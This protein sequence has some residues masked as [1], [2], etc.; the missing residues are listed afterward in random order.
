[1]SDAAANPGRSLTATTPARWRLPALLLLVL[2]YVLS[3]RLGLML[4]IPPGYASAIFPPAGIALAA[5][6]CGGSVTLPW[7]FAG[8]LLLNLWVSFGAAGQL[9]GRGVAAGLA[10]ALA[11]S[12]QA[13]VG[14]A[15]LRRALG[16]PTPM[17]NERSLLRFILVSPLICAVSASV[18]VPSLLWLGFIPSDNLA[19]SWFTWWIG[20]TLG[21]LVMMPLTMVLVGQPRALWRSRAA[22]LYAPILIGFCLFVVIFARLSQW[23][24]DQSLVEFKLLSRQVSER[25]QT[26]LEAQEALLEQTERLFASSDYVTRAEFK[27]FTDKA[28]IRYPMIRAIEW[29][30]LVTAAQR[31]TYEQR[32]RLEIREI[33]ASAP[34]LVRALSREIYFP[35]TYTE[36]SLG[37]ETVP[38]LDIANRI[39]LKLLQKARGSSHAVAS[40]PVVL[41]Q[42][43]ASKDAGFGALILYPIFG[44]KDGKGSGDG[45]VATVLRMQDFIGGITAFAGSQ[46]FMRFEDIDAGKVI[47]DSFPEGGPAPGFESPL[48]FGGRH[49]RFEAAPT[50]VYVQSHRGWQSWGMLV[51]GLF[52]IG[53]LTAALLLSTG[54]AARITLEVAERTAALRDEKIFSEKVINNLPGVFYMLDANGRMVHWNRNFMTVFGLT[55]EQLRTGDVLQ[56]TLPEDQHIARA[57][58]ERIYQ[59]QGYQEVEIRQRVADGQVRRYFANGQYVEIAGKTYLIGTGVDITDRRD[60]EQEV[61]RSRKVLRTLIDA[62][63]VWLAMIDLNGRMVIANRRFAATFGLPQDFIEGKH[64]SAVLPPE[65][66]I[67][68]E[69][70]FETSFAGREVEFNDEWSIAGQPTMHVHG[71]CV[72]VL[73]GETVVSIVMVLMDLTEM[74]HVQSSLR[75][76]NV[77]LERRVDEIR[78]LQL[79]LQEQATRDPLTG[80]YNRRHL[81]STLELELTRAQREGYPVSIV[82]GD[83]D[84]FKKLNDTYGHQ[85]GDEMIRFLAELLTAQSRPGDTLC[86][87]GGEEFL[88]VMPGLSRQDAYRRVDQLREKFAQSRLTFGAFELSTTISFGIAAYPD[89]GKSAERLIAAADHALYEAKAHG[90]NRVE[91]SRA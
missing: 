88:L 66:S 56:N 70:L 8:S 71:K 78:A 1:M 63:P 10:I 90:R 18:S 68:M 73:D 6:L 43:L 87:Y 12:L 23:E 69:S 19:S 65:T 39:G 61:Q 4:A 75:T 33:S 89:D 48:E 91:Q 45:F 7:I 22:A 67:R 5:A 74:H 86:R 13:A 85:A 82:M 62:A 80:L 14:G 9:D 2:A 83:I 46:M 17:D 72:P 41:V 26:S 52:F 36:P 47:F 15:V 59:K 30:P 50:P 25:V 64:Y 84:H 37:N 40:P 29:M 35:V 31:T 27:L 16:M 81:D 38:G 77:A 51:A 49:Y 32:E 21:V 54:H 3:G 57:A 20:D 60:M 76:A 53:L 79:Q 24:Q 34:R 44:D 42:D 55:E 11:S 58:I 28:L